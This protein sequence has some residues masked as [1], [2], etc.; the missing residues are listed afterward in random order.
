MPWLKRKAIKSVALVTLPLSLSLSISSNEITMT[1]IVS[2]YCTR[3]SRLGRTTLVE[4]RYP[5]DRPDS[6]SS[7]PTESPREF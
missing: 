3:V 6:L 4:N 1:I 7:S 5:F 2:Y